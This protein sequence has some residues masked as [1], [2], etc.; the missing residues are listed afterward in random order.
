MPAALVSAAVMTAMGADTVR[1]LGRGAVTS[2]ACV[3]VMELL[4]KQAQ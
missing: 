4:V 2:I 3:R 1:L